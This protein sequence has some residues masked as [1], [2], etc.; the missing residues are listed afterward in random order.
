MKAA[1]R[2]VSIAAGR[3]AKRRKVSA[4]ACRFS[5]SSS[6]GGASMNSAKLS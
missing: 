4:Q 2:A 5:S 6:S 3:A 1:K